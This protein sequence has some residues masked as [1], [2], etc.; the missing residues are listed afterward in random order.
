MQAWQLL[1]A[2]TLLMLFG[3][4]MLTAGL[5]LL[6]KGL[7]PRRKGTDPHCRHCHYN[8]TGLQ[9]GI[10]PECGHPWTFATAAI[11]YRQ[12]RPILAFLGSVA[13]MGACLCFV[14]P[15]AN[16]IANFKYIH[17]MPTKVLLLFA[18]P[19]R[20][21][22]SDSVRD[23]IASRLR[24]CEL[25][26]DQAKEFLRRIA[27]MELK[28]RPRVLEGEP[29]PCAV[30]Y[31]LPYMKDINPESIVAHVKIE[32]QLLDLFPGGASGVLADYD[33]RDS[34][35]MQCP[36]IGKHPVLADCHL[37]YAVTYWNGTQ[38]TIQND[39]Q[40]QAT[41]EV[42]PAST[43]DTVT[44]VR[45]QS[46]KED[47]QRRIDF[48]SCHITPPHK[49]P[50][51]IQICFTAD[52]IPVELAFDVFLRVRGKEY[53]F[54]T[55]T[56]PKDC[57]YSGYQK[58]A[59]DGPVART[60]DIVLRSNPKVARQTVDLTEMWE[61]ELV[62]PDLPLKEYDPGLSPETQPAI[63]TQ[64]DSLPGRADPAEIE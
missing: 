39:L 40:L 10:C 63:A 16:T 35:F 41:C 2:E 45:D 26:P 55:L 43:R 32:D 29:V 51:S 1:L 31:F 11:G 17:V 24:A 46:L 6:K 60:I 25:Q 15:H 49:D 34:S 53:P 36:R 56:S 9:E 7:W 4:L 8:L 42:I 19:A 62:F 37:E 27:K 47:L 38:R 20:S 30:D 48:Y 58:A 54:N 18:D 64:V 5:V 13:L 12:R 44:I 21:D 33:F 3:L 22:F 59:Y 50:Q 23:E 61:G 14:I 57:K 28:V 52:H